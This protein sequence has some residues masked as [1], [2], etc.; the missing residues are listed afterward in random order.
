VPFANQETDV[1][2]SSPTILS[3]GD[4]HQRIVRAIELELGRD[5]LEMWLE[6]GEA[7]QI[8]SEAKAREV[9]VF[10]PT[11]FQLNRI[12]SRFACGLR[13]AVCS[14]LGPKAG[15][16]FQVN[17][18]SET[19]NHERGRSHSSGRKSSAG[20]A[21][22]NSQPQFSV[23]LPAEVESRAAHGGLDTFYFGETNRLVETGVGQLFKTLGQVSPFVVYGPP[24]C[25]KTHLL[26]SIICDAR[27]KHRL[28]RC[29]YL[30]AE[31]FT[32][33]FVQ[34]LRGTG[35]PM[36]RRKYRD[37]ELLAIDDVQFF[38]GKKATLAEFQHT[39]DHLIRNGKQIV[40]ASD[41]PPV[42]LECLGSEVTA[43]MVCGLVCPLNYPDYEG[44]RRIVANLCQQ[45]GFQI[46]LDI[47]DLVSMQIARDVR[48]LSGAINRIHAHAVAFGGE[49]TMESAKT[50]LIDLFSVGG[51]LASIDRIEK[52]V[53]EYCQVRPVD[54]K[55]NS[56]AKK[57]SAARMLAMY[58][59]RRHTSQACSE[60][61][62]YFGGR[63]HSTVIAAQKK[64]ASWLDSNQSINLPH[65]KFN[66]KDAVVRIESK[67]R[68][69]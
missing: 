38:A 8:N 48:R 32:T 45:R 18:R 21:C 61:G 16:D 59:A 14:V 9:V 22:R 1:E 34:S 27:R 30:S 19:A 7:I 58:L 67:L 35:L 39:I 65:A 44:R 11:E 51:P 3:P 56:R 64:V 5:T 20:A 17:C 31:Q 23:M 6:K 53:C 33:Y 54:L 43:R 29:V 46:S 26:R 68:I 62:D 24:G 66:A 37:L 41:R 13:K 2:R 50:A 57:I 63:S 42:E 52:E 12:R 10:A 15:I 36:F 4:Y 28:S 25:G 69:G 60:I 55:S 49:M 47:Q 40:L